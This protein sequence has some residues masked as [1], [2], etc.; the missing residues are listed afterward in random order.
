MR[1]GAPPPCTLCQEPS[2]E[3]TCYS[4][5]SNFWM[6]RVPDPVA[7]GLYRV[8]V[9]ASGP[10]AIIRSY[11]SVKPL[12]AHDSEATRNGASA[13]T[14]NNERRRAE[15]GLKRGLL[16]VLPLLSGFART[17]GY[18]LFT[19]S[20]RGCRRLLTSGVVPGAAN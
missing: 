5:L 18:H 1:Y 13:A 6:V 4:E 3:R 12:S 8:S 15:G 17:F 11:Q 10:L 14:V 20:Q 9:I 7:A 16:C 2:N 19:R